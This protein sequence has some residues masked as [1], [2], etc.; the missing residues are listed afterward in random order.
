MIVSSKIDYNT[1]KIH[2]PEQVN[3]YNSTIGDNTKIASFVEIGGAT[4]GESCKIEAYSFIPPGTTIGNRVF[5][6]PHV[7]ICNDKH[8]SAVG[9]WH[10]CPVT[11]ED[12]ASIGAGSVIL[13]GVTI[14]KGAF[15]AAGSIVSHNVPAY[16]KVKGNPA[17]IYELLLVAKP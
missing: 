12:D 8:P 16:C 5:I 1:V 14:G 6:G 13:P 17:R 11:I 10:M 7:C 4:I 3:I 15:V 9:E 2:H